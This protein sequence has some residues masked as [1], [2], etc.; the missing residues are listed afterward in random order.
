MAAGEEQDCDQA[1]RGPEIAVLDDWKHV[2]SGDGEEADD[3]GNSCDCHC[4]PH[5]VDRAD[6]RRVRA[7]MNVAGEPGVD[8]V[9]FIDAEA[10][11][12]CQ[13]AAN[14]PARDVTYPDEKSKR[15]GVLSAFALGPVVGWKSSNTGAVCS[16]SLGSS[17]SNLL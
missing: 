14:G 15:R 5:V 3:A 4:D 10:E 8:R 6:E 7:G 13:C 17:A 12:H 1:D 16:C 11:C 9:G 2:W